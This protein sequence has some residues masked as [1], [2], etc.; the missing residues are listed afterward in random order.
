MSQSLLLCRYC[1]VLHPLPGR[2][3][4]DA[5]LVNDLLTFRAVHESHGLLA[6][7]RLPD[8]ALFDGPTWDPMSARWFRVAAAGEVL[9]VR[10]WRTSI[11][12]PL[13]LTVTAAP[14]P[15]TECI[16]VDEGLLRRALDRHFYPQIIRPVQV[17]RFVDAVRTVIAALD[18]REVD[19]SFDDA[20]LPNASLGPFPTALCEP[21]LARCAPFLDAWELERVRTFIAEHRLEDG[22]LAVRVRRV[23][24]RSAA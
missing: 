22:A 19:T 10:S 15:A 6:A 14:P 1:G 3:D 13:R 18:P 20:S 5:D 9:L 16:D 2:S 4:A 11:D 7:E 24:D 21:L 12:E 8:S 17:E 23:L